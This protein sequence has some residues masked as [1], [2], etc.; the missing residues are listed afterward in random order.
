LRRGRRS[1]CTLS[2]ACCFADDF[3]CCFNVQLLK[4]VA[5]H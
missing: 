1:L 2:L 3:F 5:W 4:S